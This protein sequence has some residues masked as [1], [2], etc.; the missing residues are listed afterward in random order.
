MLTL[1]PATHIHYC[2]FLNTNK[3]FKKKLMKHFTVKKKIF[4]TKIPYTANIRNTIKYQYN[5]INPSKRK[6]NKQSN[7]F[8]HK[9]FQVQS[10][11][12]VKWSEIRY[13]FCDI[14]STVVF[15]FLFVVLCWYTGYQTGDISDL[16][17]YFNLMFHK[18]TNKQINTDDYKLQLQP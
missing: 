13:V 9:H 3:R 16:N 17:L 7:I 5:H 1:R 18:Q 10:L 8:I 15:V 11:M 12:F 14:W 4:H 6:T 2:L